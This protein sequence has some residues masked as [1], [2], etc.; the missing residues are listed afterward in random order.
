MLAKFT[1]NINYWCFCEKIYMLTIE[2]IPRNILVIILILSKYSSNKN[3]DI[4]F[5]FSQS[6]VLSARK[7]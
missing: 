1:K 2:S 4:V 3:I 5:F 6:Y 7:K